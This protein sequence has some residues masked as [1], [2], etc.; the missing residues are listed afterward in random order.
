[1]MRRNISR[2][3]VLFCLL[4]ILLIL[5]GCKQVLFSNSAHQLLKDLP[6]GGVCTNGNMIQINV[7]GPG[8]LLVTAHAMLGLKSHTQGQKD[9]SMLY[10]SNSKEHCE[11]SCTYDNCP[12]GFSIAADEPSWT[13]SS[14]RLIPT[15]LDRSFNVSKAGQYSYYLNGRKL[16][17]NGNVR[18]WA[19]SLNA[20]FF[21]N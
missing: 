9:L 1:M 19:A 14:A 3:G 17:G 21:P 13:A 15:S 2:S 16:A 6:P 20:V 8:K 7:P 4:S 5:G 10:I 18:I 12:M 11:W